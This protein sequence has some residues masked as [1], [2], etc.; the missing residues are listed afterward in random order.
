MF[1]IMMTIYK[2]SIV[3]SD[4]RGVGGIQNLDKKPK[5]GDVLTLSKDKQC[6]KI[7]NITEIMPPRGHFIY[8]HVICKTTKNRS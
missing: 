2:L 6:Y 5:I 4:K 8:L 7:T 3:V 1:N